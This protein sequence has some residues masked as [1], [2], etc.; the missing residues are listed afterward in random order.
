[1]DKLVLKQ[2]ERKWGG[3]LSPTG[4][5]VRSVGQRL[6]LPPEMNGLLLL[7]LQDEPAQ[8]GLDLLQLLFRQRLGL[9]RLVLHLVLLL[10]QPPLVPLNLCKN[11]TFM[12]LKCQKR[13]VPGR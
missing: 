11:V 1:M 13:N 6:R 9:V 3:A 12:F 7:L 4:V 2:K 8:V 10:L 5:H